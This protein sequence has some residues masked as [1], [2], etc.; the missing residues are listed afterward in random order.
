MF[1][2]EY[3]EITVNIF[4]KILS[5]FDTSNENNPHWSIVEKICSSAVSE[6]SEV[7]QSSHLQEGEV[8]CIIIKL[9]PH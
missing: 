2:C 5:D 9:F 8:V 3:L 6:M 1:F 4:M 7:L